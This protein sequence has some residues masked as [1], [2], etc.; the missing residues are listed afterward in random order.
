MKLVVLESPYAG[1]AEENLKYLEE[2]ILDCLKRG[3]SP[4]A[5][6]KLLTGALND[7]LPEERELGIQAGFAWHAVA[8]KIVFY[9]DRG[10]SPGM[11]ESY[12]NAKKHGYHCEL[13]WL[14]S[15]LTKQDLG[16]QFVGGSQKT[17]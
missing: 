15:C 10:A 5:S 14:R 7:R 9:L 12:R 17:S 1:D 3:E 13:R 4:Y 2:C 11:K 6:H 16:L 8:D